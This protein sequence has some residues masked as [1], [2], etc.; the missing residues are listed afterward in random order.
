MRVSLVPYAV[1]HQLKFVR[2][3]TIANQGQAPK[4]AWVITFKEHLS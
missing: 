1:A 2:P 4:C 3:L